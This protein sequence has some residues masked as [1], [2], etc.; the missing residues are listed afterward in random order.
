[1]H[2]MLGLVMDKE[3]YNHRYSAK[4]A[5]PTKPT[6]YNKKTPDNATNVDRTKEKSVDKANIADLQLFADTKHE[7][8]DFATPSPSTPPFCH[9]NSWNTCTNMQWP[10]CP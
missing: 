1:M 6:I 10:P 2:N 3:D 4:F 8:V 7:S 5:T 9:R